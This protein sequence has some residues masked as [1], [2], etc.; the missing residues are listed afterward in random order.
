MTRL[1][2][3]LAV[4]LAGQAT[5]RSAT[6]LVTVSVSVKRGNSV[7]A[8]LKAADFT[9]TD[10][11]VPQTIA[12]G[13]SYS[14]SFTGAVSG[15]ADSSH[16]DVVTASGKDD[17]GNGLTDLGVWSPATATFNKRGAVA[18]ADCAGAAEMDLGVFARTSSKRRRNSRTCALVMIKGGKRRRV[19]S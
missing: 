3:L 1:S 15:N 6:S 11:G 19:K 10:S 13:P 17:D 5:F 2:L 14:C 7:V 16:T 12:P 18:A 4:L 8:N 9:L